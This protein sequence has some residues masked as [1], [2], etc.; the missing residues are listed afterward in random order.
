MADKPDPTRLPPGGVS[1]RQL[2]SSSNA[3]P[4]A[5]ALG[6]ALNK[7]AQKPGRWQQFVRYVGQEA[8][9]KKDSFPL[10]GKVGMR[11]KTLRV[12]VF[13]P[14]LRPRMNRIVGLPMDVTRSR[15]LSAGD[16]VYCAPSR[17]HP[18]NGSLL[19]APA[20]LPIK[21]RE[22]FFSHRGGGNQLF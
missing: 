19:H 11:V 20:H 12:M 18:V 9:L 1:V 21:G 17:S 10:T 15:M 8:R 16:R 7:L 3:A 6:K 5:T 14:T 2:H 22:A 13:H 4:S